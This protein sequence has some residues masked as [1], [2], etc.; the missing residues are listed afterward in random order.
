M[1]PYTPL[2]PRS[3]KSVLASALEREAITVPKDHWDYSDPIAGGEVVIGD[4]HIQG[5]GDTAGRT[6]E[7]A[8][9]G[10]AIPVA[11]SGPS[12]IGWL[13]MIQGAQGTLGIVRWASIRCR[14][15]PSIQKP[16]LISAQNLGD[17]VPFLQYI[18]RLRLG[19]ELFVL[20]TFSLA[21]VLSEKAE[22]IRRLLTSLSPWVL[23]LNLAGY[24]RHP[25]EELE[26]KEEQT[27]ELA[28]QYGLELKD[29]FSETSAYQVLKILEKTPEK[30]RRIR[31]KD[32]CQVLLFSTTLDKTPDLAATVVRIANDYGYPSSDIGIYIQPMIQG[33]QCE[34][35]VILPYDVTDKQEVERVKN[36]YS[37]MAHSLSNAGAYYSRPYG[38]LAEITYRDTEVTNVLRKIKGILDPNGIM[39]SGKLCF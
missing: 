30:D 21:N 16:F 3:T 33:C 27:K 34:F 15:K 10:E 20:N 22:V 14:I 8:A 9:K 35:E 32:S 39:N 7:E 18:L 13:T 31:F 5:F 37:A 17:I 28:L 19:E 11:P 4:G 23:F 29:V 25:Q 26:W 6:K 2:L 24:E 1:V 38:I 12:S 36:Q